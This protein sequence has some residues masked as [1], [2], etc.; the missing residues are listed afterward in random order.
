MWPTCYQLSR[1]K[2]PEGFQILIRYEVLSQ[3]LSSKESSCNTGGPSLIP[4]SGRFLE[5]GNDNLI[6]YYCLENSMNRGAWHAAVHGFTELNMTEWLTLTLSDMKYK[7]TN[8]ASNCLSRYYLNVHSLVPP[9]H[10]SPPTAPLQ[11]IF[12]IVHPVSVPFCLA[13]D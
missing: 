12:L 5:K 3:C 10:Q 2:L 4:E 8:I 6:L 11:Y 13:F 7:S 1:K 9:R